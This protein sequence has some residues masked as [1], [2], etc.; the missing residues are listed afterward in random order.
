M[1]RVIRTDSLRDTDI[2]L[3]SGHLEGVTGLRGLDLASRIVDDLSII[4]CDVE[5]LKLPEDAGWVYIRRCT[6]LMRVRDAP[7]PFSHHEMASLFLQRAAVASGL[8]QTVA[9]DVGQWVMD[10]PRA[11]W[12]PAWA[13]Y[14]D[15]Y[16][17]RAADEAIKYACDGRPNLLEHWEAIKAQEK[18]PAL[19]VDAYPKLAAFLRARTWTHSDDRYEQ[20][21]WLEANWHTVR[22][23]PR[24]DIVSPARLHVHIA[25][26]DPFSYQVRVR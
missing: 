4:D 21:R 3:T 2:D 6:G 13:I 23:L 22:F 15:K 25:S 17:D 20:S 1:S 7:D 5:G 11:S 10:N 19:M 8:I 18:D 24:I 9:E 12:R 26:L 16:G 14:G